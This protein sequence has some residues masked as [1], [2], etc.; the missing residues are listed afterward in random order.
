MNYMEMKEKSKKKHVKNVSVSESQ[1][2]C[3]VENSEEPAW[4]SLIVPVVI[5]ATLTA[6]IF[7]RTRRK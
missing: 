7:I 6:L 4:P 1:A 2:D 3:I 5:C